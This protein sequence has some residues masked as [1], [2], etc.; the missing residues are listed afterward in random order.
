[1]NQGPLE[2]V[3]EGVRC[4]KSEIDSGQT[5]APK[6]TARD[7]LPWTAPHA[8]KDRLSSLFHFLLEKRI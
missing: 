8:G 1:M 4:L 2:I 5:I 6:A 3:Q 7:D